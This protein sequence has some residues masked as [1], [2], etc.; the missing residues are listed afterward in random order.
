MLVYRGER[1]RDA[2]GR[3]LHDFR[4]LIESSARLFIGIMHSL[5]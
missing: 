2:C 4:G 1:E 5:F 3:Y